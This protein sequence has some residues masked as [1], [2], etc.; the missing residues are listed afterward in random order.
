MA[1]DP[2]T[3][4][5]TVK[6]Y[7]RRGNRITI[8]EHDVPELLELGGRVA[9]PEEL[10][11]HESEA[12]KRAAHERYDALPTWRK[13]AGYTPLG[14]LASAASAATAPDA[15]LGSVVEAMAG[16][17]DAPPTLAALGRGVR[18]GATAGLFDAGQRK[19]VEALGDEGAG[20]R[21]A[22]ERRGE[23]AAA[24]LAHG[25]GEVAGLVGG[26]LLSG[27]ASVGARAAL[28]AA[29]MSRLGAAAEGLVG[30]KLLG[31]VASKGALGRATATAAGLGVRGAVE[32]MAYAGVST[33]ADTVTHDTPITGEKIYAAIGH[34]AILGGGL[35]SALGF[36]GSLAA[37][38]AR[39]VLGRLVSRAAGPVDDVAEAAV[40]ASTAE[41]APRLLPGGRPP[42][43][44][45]GPA[46]SP[47][48]GPAGPRPAGTPASAARELAQEQAWRAVAAGFGLQS[49]KYAKQAA[50]YFANGTRDLGEVMLRHGIIDMG[51]AAATPLQAAIA[52][53]KS[54]RVTE[55]LPKLEAALSNVGRQI[56][57]LTERSG[58][59]IDGSKVFQAIDEVAKKYE[60]SAATRPAG[61]ALRNF[62]DDLVDS[63]QVKQPGSSASVQDLLRERKAIDRIT[64][65]D[66]PTLD[67]KVA[68]EARRDLRA[69]LESV[70]TD[71][72]DEAS[73]KVPGELRAQYK[74]LKRDYHALRILNEAAED[75]AARVAKGA[76][77]GL[78]DK[79]L[80]ATGAT[81]GAGIGGP[82][83]AVVAGPA[84]AFASR[85]VRQRGNAAAAAFLTRVA[86]RGALDG[87]VRSQNRRIARAAAGVLR[88]T[89]PASVVLSRP[90][91]MG[92]ERRHDPKVGRAAAMRT[93][94]R[95][96]AVA[97]SVAELQA[98][99]RRLLRELEE[100]AAIVGPSAGP[101]AADA[102]TLSTMRALQFIAGFV[103]QR[104][105]RDPLDPRSVPPLTYD[106][107]DRLLR[108]AKYATKPETI[109]DDLEGAI[110]RPEAVAAAKTFLPDSFAEFQA[111]LLNHVEAHMR[112]GRRL[113][114]AQRLRV[115]RLL[116]FGAARPEKIA[117]LQANFAEAPPEGAAPAPGGGGP[118]NLNIPQSGFD[119]VEAR[120][121]T[122]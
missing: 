98:D 37:S 30:R 60:I 85:I 88:E 97:S 5:A 62:G 2:Q 47:S 19:V 22:A 11:A 120:S 115:D 66:A 91:V 78:T 79:M 1:T 21:F 28:P 75:S 102:Y 95:A 49:T 89:P 107:A 100:A 72:L 24:P 44:A 48:G 29:G 108:A 112:R 69:K 61:R 7:D 43:P 38:G 8:A 35:G 92:G 104:E 39:S 116:G 84:T 9:T 57:E 4:Q 6:A 70:I 33:L 27:G 16:S 10:Q 68:L 20:E 53:A 109:W 51:D 63:L 106:E 121:A 45:R 42:S 54:G 25:V 13:V 52:A 82:V 67:P 26:A 113:S 32:G 117:L 34:A 83:G 31:G 118:L 15:S 81:I 87:L 76:G 93:K 55:M 114:H 64:F 101:R 110:V 50:K 119:A 77:F 59:R 58:A 86:D 74:H 105:R 94:A 73:G 41:G 18:R 36:G 90:V 3:E 17:G 96:Q 122:R 56:G 23:Q 40:G 103:P 111:Q 46:P 80:G 12:A 71:A 99:P 65:R 14:H